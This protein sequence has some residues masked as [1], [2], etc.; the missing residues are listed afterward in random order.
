MRACTKRCYLRGACTY[1]DQP[2]TLTALC[3]RK[4]S[5]SSSTADEVWYLLAETCP[6]QWLTLYNIKVCPFP[7]RCGSL[8]VHELISNDQCSAKISV[9]AVLGY[10]S[11][12]R[13]EL[14]VHNLDWLP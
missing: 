14:I 11:I 10:I 12:Y 2:A 4:Q 6:V 9:Y 5:W 7:G 8:I 1:H 13:S 3:M